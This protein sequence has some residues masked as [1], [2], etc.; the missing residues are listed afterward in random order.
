[1]RRVMIPI[2]SV[3]MVL[4][5]T[6]TSFGLINPKFTPLQLVDQSDRVLDQLADHAI[7]VPAIVADLGILAGLDFD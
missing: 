3:A 2:A 4:A 5:A 1:M 6:R 7:D